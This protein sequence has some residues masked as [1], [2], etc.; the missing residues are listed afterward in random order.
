M[1]DYRFLTTWLLRAELEPVFDAIHDTE[2]W[3]QWWPGV[4]RVVARGGGDADGVGERFQIVW[5]S[6]LPYDLTFETEVTRVERPRV[7]E[8]VA[9]G[10]LAGTGRWRLYP[11][12]DGLVVVLYEWNVATTKRWM[13]ALGPLARPVFSSNHDHVMRAGGRGLAQLLGVELVAHG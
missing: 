2:A 11:D 6:F 8:G 10:E 13:N 7:M 12:A 9:Q 4:R 3:P 5:R 1:A